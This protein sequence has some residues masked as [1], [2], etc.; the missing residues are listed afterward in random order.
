MIQYMHAFYSIQMKVNVLLFSLL[1]GERSIAFILSWYW[2]PHYFQHLLFDVES[3]I[4]TPIIK[5][6]IKEPTKL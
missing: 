2:C 6:K 5:N 3:Y 1:N 4:V